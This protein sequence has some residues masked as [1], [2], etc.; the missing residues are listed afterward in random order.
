MLNIGKTP[1]KNK[2]GK[3]PSELYSI[4]CPIL[5]FLSHIIEPI[6]NVFGGKM[7]TN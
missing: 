2:Y 6:Y 1:V 7:P 3:I 4:S 5:K